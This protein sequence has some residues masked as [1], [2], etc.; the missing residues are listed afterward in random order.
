M[1]KNISKPRVLHARS[2]HHDGYPLA[3]LVQ[4]H[5][6]LKS[7]LVKKVDGELSVNFSDPDAVKAL[8]TALLAYYYQVKFWDIPQG[9]LCPPIPGRADYVHYIADLLAEDN[10]GQV[11]TGKSV[12]GIDIGTGANLVYPLLAQKIYAWKML[13]TDIDG[14]AIKSAENIIFANKGLTNNIKVR[15]QNSASN[16]FKGIIKPDEHYRFCMCNPPFHRSAVQAQAGSNRKLNNLKSHAAKRGSQLKS[17]TNPSLNFA[18]QSNELWCDGGELAFIQRMMLQSQD[19]ASQIQWF[20]SL[21][22]KQSHIQPLSKYLKKLSID[23][24]RVVEMAQGQ[25]VSRFIAWRFN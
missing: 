14:V 3:E 10:Q 20:T 2:L 18:G 13:G 4:K 22:S 7:F 17:S 23:T 24:I 5:I 8:N 25:K 16:I 1:L 21:V 15:H 6:A 12:K 11:P 19:Y 9:Y